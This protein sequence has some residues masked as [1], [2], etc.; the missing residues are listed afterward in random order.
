MPYSGDSMR[1]GLGAGT[2]GSAGASVGSSVG[3]ASGVAAPGAT[4]SPSGCDVTAGAAVG[5]SCAGSVGWG[6]KVGR[7]VRVGSPSGEPA[8]PGPGAFDG[9]TAGLHAA[10]TTMIRART[11]MRVRCV[12][13]GCING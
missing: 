8:A 9:V 1:S 5:S 7:S 2:A 13:D 12:R 6:V 3:S 11:P 4:V 10:N